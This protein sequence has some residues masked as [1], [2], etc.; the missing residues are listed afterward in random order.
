MR[1][2]S[3]FFKNTDCSYFP[4]H[5]G[6]DADDFNCLFCYCP[7]YTREVCPGS[8]DFITKDGGSV[9]KRCVGCAF[10][11]RPENYERIISLLRGAKGA[12]DFAEYHHGGERRPGG[13]RGADFLD[14]SVNVN[15]L[16]IPPRVIEAVQNALPE[17]ARYPDQHCASLREKIAE[18]LAVLPGVDVSA[19]HIVCGNGASEL[20][21]LVASSVAPRNALVLAPTFS[22]YEKSLKAVRAKIHHHFLREETGFSLDETIFDSIREAAPDIIFLCSPN[23]PTGRVIDK[24][25]LERVAAYCDGAGIFL[26]VDECFLG[27]TG[28]AA[29]TAARLVGKNPH[30]VVLSALTKIYA[31][32]GIRLGFA[33]SSNHALLRKINLLRPEWSVSTLAQVAGEAA[34]DED[35]YIEETIR[36]VR[37]EREFLSAELKALGFEVFL[38]EANFLLFRSNDDKMS[39]K[40]DDFLLR[41]GISLRNC[42]NF[43]GLA[44]RFYR[45]AVRARKEN[46]RLV[47]ILSKF[48]I[49]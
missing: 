10:P 32:A 4:C 18:K 9:V 30:L 48:V 20:I 35:G 39:E 34:L 24:N 42:G 29:E 27:F 28:R 31:L 36:A 11:H 33:L 19:S 12:F 14:F 43:H 21:S 49:C 25:L 23:N 45:T 37:V 5:G 8:P 46:A 40:L 47:E 17:I 15:P 44:E 26:V 22:G 3:R 6:V 2:T 13:Q 38:G 7:L 1:N 16:G 41:N